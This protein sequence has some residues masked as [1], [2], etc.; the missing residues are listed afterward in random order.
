MSSGRD[1]LERR[2][3]RFLEREF[4]YTVATQNTQKSI[5]SFVV[6]M[7]WCPK[8][9]EYGWVDYTLRNYT[10]YNNMGIHSGDNMLKYE[11]ICLTR[12]LHEHK[13]ELRMYLL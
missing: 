3:A 13:E 9:T 1:K 11:T 4:N 2:Y 10:G 12:L 8:N 6:F 5:Y 7:R